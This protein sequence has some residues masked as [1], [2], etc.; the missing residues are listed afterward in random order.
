[1]FSSLSIDTESVIL[2]EDV[3][4]S[5]TGARARVLLP[6]PS[7]SPFPAAEVSI[8]SQVLFEGLA[9][10][11]LSMRELKDGWTWIDHGVL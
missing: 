5:G 2:E 6:V 1:M 7:S 11:F 8:L 3:K 10:I 9:E 4:I